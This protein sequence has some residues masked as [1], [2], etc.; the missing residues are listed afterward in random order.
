MACTGRIYEIDWELLQNSS[1]EEL[2]EMVHCLTRR[3]L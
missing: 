1:M 3:S 2:M